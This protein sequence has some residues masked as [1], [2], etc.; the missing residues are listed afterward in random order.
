LL[1]NVGTHALSVPHHAKMAAPNA[2]RRMIPAFPNEVSL[3][4]LSNLEIDDLLICYFVSPTWKIAI[5][6][7]NTLREKMF[8]LPKEFE[9]AEKRLSRRFVEDLWEGLYDEVWDFKYELYH[10]L[11]YVHIN[12]LLENELLISDHK[13][14]QFKGPLRWFIPNRA[15][16]RPEEQR[17]QRELIRSMFL[18][19]PPV[20]NHDVWKYTHTNESDRDENLVF[21][22]SLFKP[23]GLTFQNVEDFWRSSIGLYSL[24]R[25][26]VE[27]AAELWPRFFYLHSFGGFDE[28]VYDS[29]GESEEDRVDYG[30]ESED[31]W[32]PGGSKNT[33][34]VQR[35]IYLDDSD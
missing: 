28:D 23:R 30:D 19:W 31:D 4:V 10:A 8:R 3:L 29:G 35:E 6:N 27:Y 13:L 14:L 24:D 21:T 25:P 7:E 33:D 17:Q 12:P 20:T 5:D 26:G 9:G 32:K 15:Q 22:R 1:F 16:L 34:D 18:T 11:K 2:V